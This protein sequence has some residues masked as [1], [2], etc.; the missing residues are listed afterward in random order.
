MI[1]FMIV[2]SGARQTIQ[3]TLEIETL[4]NTDNEYGKIFSESHILG[5]STL[6]FKKC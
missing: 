1:F 4:N 5:K 2:A 3:V 6:S